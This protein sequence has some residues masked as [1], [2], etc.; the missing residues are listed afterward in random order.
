MTLREKLHKMID[1]AD[2]GA[3]AHFARQFPLGEKSAVSRDTAETSTFWETLAE[4]MDKVD[5]AQ[6]SDAVERRPF[7][8]E[9]GFNVQPD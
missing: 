7:F 4:P 8:D 1:Q 2:E 9:D 6:L 5:Q 3:L